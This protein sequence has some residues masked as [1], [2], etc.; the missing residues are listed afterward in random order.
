MYVIMSP[1]VY[2]RASP[3]MPVCMH[4]C[5]CREYAASIQT[6]NIPQR[7]L[8]LLASDSKGYVVEVHHNIILLRRDNP[9]DRIDKFSPIYVI[10]YSC[11]IC[12]RLPPAILC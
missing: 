4:V 6:Q 1:H 8:L 3:Y 9:K 7:T 12:Q 2:V 10:S 5:V 11:H